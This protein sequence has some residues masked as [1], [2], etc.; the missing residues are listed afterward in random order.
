MESVSITTISEKYKSIQQFFD[1]RSKRIWAAAEAKAIGRGGINAVRAATGMGYFTI[2]KGFEELEKSPAA[3]QRIRHPGGG[4]KKKT[5]TDETLLSDLKQIIDPLTRG[6]PMNPLLWTSKS[7]AKI[8]VALKKEKHE[9]GITTVRKLLKQLGYSLQSNRKRREGEDHPDRNSQFE[10]I[11]ECVREQIAHDEPVISI[12]AK[13]KENLGNYS[14]KGQEYQPKKHPLEVNMHDFPNKELGK[15]IP[16][17]IYDLV[18]NRGFVN[19]GIDHAVMLWGAE[20]AVNSI[21]AWWYELGKERFPKATTLTIT[22]DSG[23]SNSY[24]TKLWKYELQKLADEVRLDIIVHHFP[25]GT[26]KWNKIEH[27]LFSYIT[28]NWRGHPLIDLATV[29]NLIANTKTETGL[30]VRCVEDK[31]LYEKGIKINDSE[32]NKIDLQPA[33]FL[34]NWNYSIKTKKIKNK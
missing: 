28:K 12:D 26:S 2:K 1:E 31:K 13:K 32:L 15:A 10:Y 29:I 22:A 3:Q 19:V 5:E 6:D 34:G 25:P 11:N 18:N 24:R 8:V 4:R 14:N 21:R 7:L 33:T 30:T 9:V 20:F 27:R 16:Y 23:G 17:G